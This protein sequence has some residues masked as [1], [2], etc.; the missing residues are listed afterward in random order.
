M[1]ECRILSIDGGGVQAVMTTLV[2]KRIEEARPGTIAQVDIFAGTSA[3][4]FIALMLAAIDDPNEALLNA[5][6]LWT[7]WGIYEMNPLRTIPVAMGVSA[8]YSNRKLKQGLTNLFGSRTLGD[9]QRRV[10]IPS[11][12]LDDQARDP[13]RRRW[14]P[15]I[16]HNFGEDLDT[17]LDDASSTSTKL[18]DVALRTSA[19]PMCFPVYQGYVDG[20]LY[21]NNPSMCA[22]SLAL[23]RTGKRS[24]Q[25]RPL[26]ARVEDVVMFSM[27]EG[28]KHRYLPVGNRSENWGWG[29]WITDPRQ[30]LALLDVAIDSNAEIIDYQCRRMLS[31]AQYFRL[32]PETPRRNSRLSVDEEIPLMFEWALEV[33]IDPTL[34][35]LDASRWFEPGESDGSNESGARSRRRRATPAAAATPTASQESGG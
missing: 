1:A 16:F 15:M 30:P 8:I 23:D 2:L 17:F 5:L 10:V 25:A 14:R 34:A 7:E 13:D 4:G 24:T 18:V 31:G 32:D 6:D 11:F 22:L 12:Q 26:P 20:G 21:A 28:S 3:G 29:H 33:D 9:L 35:W 19:S 27:G